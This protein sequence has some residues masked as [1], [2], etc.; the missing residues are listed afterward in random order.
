MQTD[1]Q[2]EG[3]NLQNP[4]AV[5][6]VVVLP[7]GV[8]EGST[9]TVVEGMDMP[10]ELVVAVNEVAVKGIVVAA[11]VVVAVVLVENAEGLVDTAVVDTAAVDGIEVG[12][13]D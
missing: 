10:V 9:D 5:V 7:V 6:V 1:Q 2:A 3:N 12:V 11:V 8:V 4:V 13:V